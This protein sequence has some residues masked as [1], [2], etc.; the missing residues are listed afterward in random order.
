MSCVSASRPVL[1]V[2]EGGIEQVRS[3]STTAKAGNIRALRMLTL[4]L[5][6]GTPRTAFR[7]T[8]APVPA[9]VGIATCGAQSRA[10]ALPAPTTSR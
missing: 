8:S 7:V 6:S 2:T 9:V 5:C 3:G 4:T 1:A 10:S